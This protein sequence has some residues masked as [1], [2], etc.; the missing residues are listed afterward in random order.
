[1][2]DDDNFSGERRGPDWWIWPVMALAMLGAIAG[3]VGSL[4]RLFGFFG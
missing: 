1:M 4:A 2:S 3:V